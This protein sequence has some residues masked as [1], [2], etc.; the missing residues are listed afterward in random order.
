[1]FGLRC[2]EHQ[3]SPK[4]LKGPLTKF[5]LVIYYLPCLAGAGLVAWLSDVLNCHGETCHLTSCTW[6]RAAK[7]QSWG[8]QVAPCGWAGIWT[9]LFDDSDCRSVL[10]NQEWEESFPLVCGLLQR[11]GLASFTQSRPQN[12]DL[13]LLERIKIIIAGW[14]GK[15]KAK[16]KF[17]FPIVSWHLFLL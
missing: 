4:Y 9:W 2:S 5:A 1:M 16:Q 14:C 6:K 13:V 11:E 7:E 3:A 17:F 12:A 15:N 10:W 8:L